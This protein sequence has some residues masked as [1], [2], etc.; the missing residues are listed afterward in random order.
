VVVALPEPL[1]VMLALDV[2]V[3]ELLR[4]EVTVPVGDASPASQADVHRTART[5]LP[6]YSAM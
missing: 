4:V 2:P 3:L 5:T 6:E 1:E